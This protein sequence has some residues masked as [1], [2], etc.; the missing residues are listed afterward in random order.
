MH[1]VVFV[2][3]ADAFEA[4]EKVL[5]KAFPKATIIVPAPT[6]VDDDPLPERVGEALQE[7]RRARVILLNPAP[8]P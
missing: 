1:F 6:F 5:Q 8:T 2:P 3:A 4:M 7:K